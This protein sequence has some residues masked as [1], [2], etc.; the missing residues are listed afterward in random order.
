ML[1][2]VTYTSGGATGNA[3]TQ[4]PLFAGGTYTIPGS[5][6]LSQ[7]GYTFSGWSDGAAIH[8]PG[9]VLVMPASNQSYTA[10]WTLIPVVVPPASS[11]SSSNSNGTG[12][13]IDVSQIPATLIYG[14]SVQ[15]LP[16]IS[17]LGS[18][19]TW[20]TSSPN[21]SVTA[22][23]AVSVLRAGPCELTVVDAAASNLS[24]SV[25]IQVE[26]RLDLKLT[27]ITNLTTRSATISAVVAWPGTDFTV[28]FCITTSPLS[29]TCVAT[30]TIAISNESASSVNT[31]GALTLARD[32]DG[33][34]PGQT[35]FVHAAVLAFSKKFVAT[36]T[37]L[38]TPAEKVPYFTVLTS[39]STKIDWS[40]IASVASAKVLFGGQ[41]ICESASASCVVPKLYGPNS[42]LQ[43]LVTYKNGQLGLPTSIGY[44]KSAKPV[45]INNLSF[46]SGA[47]TVSRLQAARIQVTLKLAKSLGFTQIVTGNRYLASSANLKQATRAR[48]LFLYLTRVAKPFGLTVVSA[49]KLKVRKTGS[50]D[51]KARK[52]T[53]QISV[54]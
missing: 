8:Q 54:N 46:A 22:D 17:P 10:M 40:S 30:S 25:V 42:K 26:P 27:E 41:V 12:P 43:L 49:S 39:K 4:S 29:D 21:C 48:K 38:V 16:A 2:H 19:L 3:P 14:S 33:L 47:M 50:L 44:A 53:L 28:K 9:E 34:E 37:T 23:G 15:K 51:V 18:P 31:S 52:R 1:Y 32:I 35:Y 20:S 11:S 13:Q 6:S 7:V 36:A 24:R 5:G 45:S